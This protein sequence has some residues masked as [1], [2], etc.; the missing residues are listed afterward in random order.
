[1]N[2]YQ[3][4]LPTSQALGMAVPF[5]EKS[6]RE[7]ITNPK[8]IIRGAKRKIVQTKQDMDQYG[9]AGKNNEED[10]DEVLANIQ[11][12]ELKFVPVRYSTKGEA[13]DTSYNVWNG[14]LKYLSHVEKKKA[15]DTE[16]AVANGLIKTLE[17]NQPIDPKKVDRTKQN[18]FKKYM[19]QAYDATL[20][21]IKGTKNL[22]H[23]II[24]SFVDT[25]FYNE[26]YFDGYTV[27]G[28]NSH[29]LIGNMS[30]I[31]SFVSLGLAPLNWATNAISGN[32][33]NLVMAAGK[34]FFPKGDLLWAKKV[35]YGDWIVGGAKYGNMMNDFRKDFTKVGNLS[36]WGQM[37]QKIGRASCRERV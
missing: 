11:G 37:F 6:K 24:Q 25:T 19:G 20:T 29:K 7:R 10:V 32:I 23:K 14:M 16:L 15:L 22:R 27:L 8:G 36:F 13:R 17:R 31:A 18:V 28:I 1:M 4:G 35:I 3:E 9:I 33:Q 30:G 5:M 34:Q 21:Y 12:E 26:D 2:E